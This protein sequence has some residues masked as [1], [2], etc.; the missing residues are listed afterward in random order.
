MKDSYERKQERI[1]EKIKDFAS[2]QN[3]TFYGSNNVLISF[4]KSNVVYSPSAFQ[5]NSGRIIVHFQQM[6]EFNAMS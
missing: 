1:I 6:N 4:Q 3:P 5:T 2:F